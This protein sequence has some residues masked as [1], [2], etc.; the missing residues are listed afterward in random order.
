MF[1]GCLE[2]DEN[3]KLFR[4]RNIETDNYSSNKFD[5]AT[6]LVFPYSAV[7]GY[8][9]EKVY[10]LNSGDDAGIWEYSKYNNIVME[11]DD[12]YVKQ[13]MFCLRRII[14]GFFKSDRKPNI[15]IA[16]DALNQLYSVFQK[17]I[18]KEKKLYVNEL[19]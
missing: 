19:N 5:T 8:Y 16:Q 10:R 11:I 15:Q 4:V 6:E 17:P 18:L 1:E 14:G 2:L 7:K 3:Q 9:F 12:K 13:E